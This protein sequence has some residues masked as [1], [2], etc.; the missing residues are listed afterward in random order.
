M[1]KHRFIA[2]MLAL[3]LT[4]V[5]AHSALAMSSTNYKIEWI[6]AGNASSGGVVT[7]TN[8]AARVTIGQNATGNVTGPTYRGTLGYWHVIF[9]QTYLPII[10]R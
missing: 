10:L 3:L 9:S 7:S 1:K 4:L 8:Y 6:L 5:I 2:V